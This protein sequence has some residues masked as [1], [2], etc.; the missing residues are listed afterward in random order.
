[1]VYGTIN[2][3][4]ELR[5]PTPATIRHAT[6]SAKARHGRGAA[7][8]LMTCW[9]RSNGHVA[10]VIHWRCRYILLLGIFLLGL[11]IYIYIYYTHGFTCLNSLRMFDHVLYIFVW[12][13]DSIFGSLK[14][15]FDWRGAPYPI[16][17]R[18]FIYQTRSRNHGV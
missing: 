10:T 14:F 18:L 8:H 7:V 9:G 4:L 1:M 6:E 15:H 5:N 12:H 13:S 2:H 11:H 16:R 17:G 3:T